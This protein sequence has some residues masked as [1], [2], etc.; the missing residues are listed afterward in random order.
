M[1][2]LKEAIDQK[3]RILID[4]GTSEKLEALV[5]RSGLERLK[6]EEDLFYIMVEKT[7]RVTEECTG[8]QQ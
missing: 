7:E 2:S 5:L 8:G 4:G 1:D 3:A 6:I